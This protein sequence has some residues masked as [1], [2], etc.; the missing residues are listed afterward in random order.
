MING[1]YNFHFETGKIIGSLKVNSRNSDI[2]PVE[3]LNIIIFESNTLDCPDLN[4]VLSLRILKNLYNKLS[5]YM[6][7]KITVGVI[8]LP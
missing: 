1:I 6:D 7:K 5:R 8:L 2:L 4:L 3:E